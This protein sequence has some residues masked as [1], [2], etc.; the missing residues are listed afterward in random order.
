[1]GRP[2]LKPVPRADIAPK[3]YAQVGAISGSLNQRLGSDLLEVKWRTGKGEALR[4]DEDWSFHP[5]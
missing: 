1:L 2:Y 5:R 4:M 3:V